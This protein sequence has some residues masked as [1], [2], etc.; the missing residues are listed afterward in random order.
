MAGKLRKVGHVKIFEID[1]LKTATIDGNVVENITAI[2]LDEID[3]K[4]NSLHN[5]SINRYF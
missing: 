3:C 2:R 5:S 1:D 4:P